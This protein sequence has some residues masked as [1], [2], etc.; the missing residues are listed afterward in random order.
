MKLRTFFNLGLRIL[1]NDVVLVCSFRLGAMCFD[2]VLKKVVSYYL[3]CEYFITLT[4]LA[5]VAI[6][7]KRLR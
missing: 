6:N 5:G 4:D 2:R 3:H 1:S 7:K